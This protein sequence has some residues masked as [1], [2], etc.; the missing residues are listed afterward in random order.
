MATLPQFKQRQVARRS[1]SDIERLSKQYQQQIAGITGDYEK[2]FATFSA[3][4]GKKE[5]VFNEQKKAY[6]AKFATYADTL[7]AYNKGMN[8]YNENI[9]KY[10]DKEAASQERVI[11]L[12]RDKYGKIYFETNGKRIGLTELTD[13]AKN[14]GFEY[15]VGPYEAGFRGTSK[16]I[17]K[18]INA[19]T[20]PVAPTAPEKFTEEQPQL[21]DIGEFDS[22]QFV[23]KKTEA[24]S[25][26]KREI[27]ERKAAKLGAVSRKATRPMLSGAQS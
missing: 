7:S 3:D 23:A 24:E 5:Q 22:S 16:V 9:G 12:P 15:V 20:K 11:E 10:L 8:A 27:G 25:T 1:T 21:P 17:A 26:L 14:Y 13:N 4:V 2:Q 19:L 6:E 18:P